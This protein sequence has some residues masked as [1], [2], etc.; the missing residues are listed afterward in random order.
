MAIV[1]DMRPPSIVVWR[2]RIQKIVHSHIRSKT[3]A[4]VI[5]EA[6]LTGVRRMSIFGVVNEMGRGRLSVAVAAAFA[7]SSVAS[8]PGMPL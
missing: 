6:G 5:V 7:N 3:A 2:L 8:L 4:F 1:T